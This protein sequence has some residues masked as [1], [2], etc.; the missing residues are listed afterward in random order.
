MISLT[1]GVSP[2]AVIHTLPVGDLGPHEDA[3]MVSCLVCF[4]SRSLG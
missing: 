1:I 4:G 2:R 3:A